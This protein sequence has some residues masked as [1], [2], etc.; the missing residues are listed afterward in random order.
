MQ[1]MS[2]WS[3]FCIDKFSREIVS[4]VDLYYFIP[5]Y[6]RST[7]FTGMHPSL[8]FRTSRTGT[9]NREFQSPEHSDEDD[10]FF[11]AQ[12]A[13][14]GEPGATCSEPRDPKMFNKMLILP[15]A[16]GVRASATSL[17]SLVDADESSSAS[18]SAIEEEVELARP[19]QKINSLESVSSSFRWRLFFCSNSDF[20]IPFSFCIL[21]IVNQWC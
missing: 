6:Y 1:L 15:R 2:L 21:L 5:A 13:M 19:L 14:S 17:H 9:L 8:E 11:D 16:E 18:D 10:Q 12:S 7:H 20:L 3:L 4:G